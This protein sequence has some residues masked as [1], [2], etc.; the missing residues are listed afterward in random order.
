MSNGRIIYK[1]TERDPVSLTWDEAETLL[2]SA[3]NIVEGIGNSLH[4]E[5][6]PREWLRR[7]S[8]AYYANFGRWPEVK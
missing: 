8:V 7:Y 5:P 2:E 1:G 4:N 6:D 3:S